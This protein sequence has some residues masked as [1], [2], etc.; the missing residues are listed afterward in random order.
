MKKLLIIFFTFLNLVVFSQNA[1]EFG[2]TYGDEPWKTYDKKNIGGTLIGIGWAVTT[3]TFIGVQK[4]N[5]T[6]RVIAYGVGPAI[7]LSGVIYW[8]KKE[9]EWKQK[10]KY[11]S[12]K[13]Y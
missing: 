5:T 10:Q 4:P 2:K 3:I 8:I 12:V 11:L 9:K 1:R 6:T 7:S 13:K